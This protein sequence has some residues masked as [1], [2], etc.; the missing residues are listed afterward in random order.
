MLVKNGVIA[1]TT[2]Q[3]KYLALPNATCFFSQNSSLIYVIVF[4]CVIG[5]CQPLTNMSTLRVSM[6]EGYEGGMAS[7]ECVSSNYTLIGPSTR[8][9]LRN[10]NWSGPDPSCIS[11]T[12]NVWQHSFLNTWE[13]LYT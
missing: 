3:T 13:I 10:G 5:N 2:V 7:Y 9:C 8:Q 12:Y 6:T 4:N 1:L 11:K